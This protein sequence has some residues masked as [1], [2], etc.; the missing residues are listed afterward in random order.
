M[1]FQVCPICANNLGKDMAAHFRVQHSH[2]LKVPLLLLL[3]TFIFFTATSS[4]P[5]SSLSPVAMNKLVIHDR[6]GNLPSQA[7]GLQLLPTHHLE[8]EHQRM[9]WIFTLKIPSATGWA[10]GHTKSLRLT[11]CSPSSSAAL[12]KPTMRSQ[13]IPTLR[14]EL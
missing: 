12:H 4:S 11:H 1:T 6:G 9:K 14:R 13:A 5:C 2:L 10:T 7:H 8:R 3:Q